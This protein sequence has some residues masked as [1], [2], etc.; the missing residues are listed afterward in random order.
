VNT[1]FV[2]PIF[3]PPRSDRPTQ[4]TPRA[5][6]EDVG[7]LLNVRWPGPRQ[8]QQ[9]GWPALARAMLAEACL[10]RGLARRRGPVRPRDRRT[11]ARWLL[12]ANGGTEAL[13]LAVA[14]AWAGLD[15]DRVRAVARLRLP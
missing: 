5:G 1:P 12:E 4:A 10:D 7:V 11:A 15:P 3:P 8:A 6:A 13:P 2:R 9:A 14:C